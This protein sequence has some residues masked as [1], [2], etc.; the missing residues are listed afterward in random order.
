MPTS[1]AS[2]RE[3]VARGWAW[4]RS[5]AHR[6]YAEPDWRNPDDPRSFQLRLIDSSARSQYLSIVERQLA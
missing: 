3:T 1:A 5:G 4:L 6:E 2:V